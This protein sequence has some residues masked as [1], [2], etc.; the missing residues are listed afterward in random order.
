M[1]SSLNFV[2]QSTQ[3]RPL[4]ALLVVVSLGLF[5]MSALDWQEARQTRRELTARLNRIDDLK[6][7]P[8]PI[9]VR[10]EADQLRDKQVELLN[11]DLGI[12]WADGFLAIE[13]AKVKTARIETI[14]W[15]GQ[16]QMIAIDYLVQSPNDLS[17]L[18]ER[19]I[20]LGLKDV[21]IVSR[22]QVPNDLPEAIRT[23]ITVRWPTSFTEQE[24]IAQVLFA[25][26]L[27]AK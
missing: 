4:H 7:N 23:K 27:R 21:H 22:Q 13:A 24:L 19:L 12:N 11:R 16:N 8:K 5:L 17:I 18:T 6:A 9:A 25:K 2:D 10:P 14:T 26:I 15:T 1:K 3:S 20:A